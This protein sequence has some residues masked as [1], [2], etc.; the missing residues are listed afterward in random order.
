MKYIK[1]DFDLY[2]SPEYVWD[3]LADELGNIGYESFVNDEDGARAF[4]PENL[5]DEEI[6]KNLLTEFEYANIIDF[7]HEE[8]E[9]K[10]WNE[11]WE[12]H[13]FEPILIDN[14]CIVHSS[15]HKDI[16]SVEFDIVIDPK[17]AFGTGH[18][19][20]TGLMIKELLKMDLT[21]KYVLDMGCGTS[22]LAILASKKGAK[23]I[24]AIDI[25]DWC[26]ENSIENIA[27]NKVEN[28]E[29]KLG[30]ASLLKGYDFDVIIANINRNI[31][32]QDMATYS[33][34]L[35][36]GGIILFSG[37]YTQDIP[38]LEEEA[39]RYGLKT[40]YTQEDNNW[41]IIKMQKQ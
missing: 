39:K 9:E 18:H 24:L 35:K 2:D 6:L 16:P 21:D 31:L 23:P 12:K 40:V 3:L 29:V 20:T 28:I 15:F 17:M 1:I 37:F 11:E 36:S 41:A 13:F 25:D 27:L 38:I 4:I 8:V 10:N 14:K 5:F 7:T 22:I 34:N 32:L 33:Q 19:Q 30:D 26:V